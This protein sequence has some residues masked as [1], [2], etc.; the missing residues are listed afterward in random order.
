VSEATLA[1]AQLAPIAWFGRLFAAEGWATVLT[2]LIATLVQMRLWVASLAPELGLRRAVGAGSRHV[3]ALVLGRAA[4][5]GGGGVLIGLVLGP[6]V[7]GALG[8]VVAGLPA[9]DFGLLARVALLL[10]AA[11]T[12]GALLPAWRAA[13][14][15]PAALLA[16][17]VA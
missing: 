4:L 16:E 2:A 3:M 9:W 15:V 11:T 13:R 5:V 14:A 1:T 12:L 7:W 10:V 6:A 8:T 17:P